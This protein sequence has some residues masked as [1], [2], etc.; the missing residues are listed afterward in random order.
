MRNE[1]G[2]HRH[3]DG[4][5]AARSE[6]R[7]GETRRRPALSVGRLELLGWFVIQPTTSS[8]GVQPAA[9]SSSVVELA[10]VIQPAATVVGVELER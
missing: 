9:T 2:A 6:R 8:A 5:A 1:D 4:A 7:R 10:A 3:R